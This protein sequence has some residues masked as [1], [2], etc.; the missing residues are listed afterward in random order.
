MG[1]LSRHQELKSLFRSFVISESDETFVDDLGAGLGCDVAV[2][3]D[4]QV[5]RNL[6]IVGCP[7]ISHRIEQCN[8]AAAGDSHK[9]IIFSG[10]AIP[11]HRLKVHPYECTY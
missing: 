5:T 1:D 10:L 9:W 2:K 4:C 3:I 8:P 7:C 6:Q 11:L